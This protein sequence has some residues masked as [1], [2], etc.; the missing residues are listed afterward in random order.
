MLYKVIL[1]YKHHLTTQGI[2]PLISFIRPPPRTIRTSFIGLL[3]TLYRKF[4]LLRL[5]LTRS[6]RL[7]LVLELMHRVRNALAERWE[8]SPRLFY[9]GFL[10]IHPTI[11]C[12]SL[13]P[14]RGNIDTKIDKPLA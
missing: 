10:F 5:C 13:P 4:R 2:I 1:P 7:K 9:C 8:D 3:R 11:S 12:A 6:P 14:L